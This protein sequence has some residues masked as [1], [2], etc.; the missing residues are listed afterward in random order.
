MNYPL[1]LQRWEKNPSFFGATSRTRTEIFL[2]HLCFSTLRVMAPI[3]FHLLR[4]PWQSEQPSRPGDWL[5]HIMDSPTTRVPPQKPLFHG[6]GP[7]FDPHSTR[8]TVPYLQRCKKKPFI[9]WRHV[10]NQSLYAYGRSCSSAFR[11]ITP[12]FMWYTGFWTT[13]TRGDWVP[14]SFFFC[15][16]SPIWTL[17]RRLCA[18]IFFFRAPQVSPFLKFYLYVYNMSTWTYSAFLLNSPFFHCQKYFK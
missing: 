16:W 18:P 4:G 7:I 11:V 3:S 8:W 15:S 9:L 13:I 1:C 2:D 10:V 12:F 6:Y 17:T 5:Q 14:A